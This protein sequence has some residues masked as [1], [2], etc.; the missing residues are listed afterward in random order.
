MFHGNRASGYEFVSRKF[1]PSL[2]FD[3]QDFLQTAT[4]STTDGQRWPVVRTSVAG[5]K[6]ATIGRIS[7][8]PGRTVQGI[9]TR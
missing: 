6:A 7:D 8:I 1:R 9:L 4:I 2:A 5:V 3:W